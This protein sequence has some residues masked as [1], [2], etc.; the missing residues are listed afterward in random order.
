MA[1]ALWLALPLLAAAWGCALASHGELRARENAYGAIVHAFLSVD[2]FYA[3]C[4]LALALF[5]LA[6]HAKGML[7]R[8]RRVT[9]D[10]A[11]LFW[12]YTVL[13][14]LAGLALVQLFPRMV[15]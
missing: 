11:M 3:A 9:F 12:H 8:D 5:A 15:A 1:A 10:N 4:A 7:D 14:S 2:A 6:R 13:Q